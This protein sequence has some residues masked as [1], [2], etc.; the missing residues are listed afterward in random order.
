[1]TDILNLTGNDDRALE[2]GNK[3][4]S[5]YR[6]LLYTVLQ[7]PREKEQGGLVIA[8]SSSNPGEGVTYVS[9]ALVHELAKCGL[10]SVAGVNIS[11]LKKLHEPTVEAI[12]DSMSRMAAPAGG[13]GKANGKSKSL[14][15]TPTGGPWEARWQYRRDCINLLRAEFDYTIIDCPSLGESAELLGIAPFVDGIVLVV[16][17][18]RTLRDQPRQAEQQISAVGGTLLGYILNKRVYEAPRWLRPDA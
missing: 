8:M 15:F 12:R 17:A 6:T 9:R 4:S 14:T 13:D 1:M 10:T 7:K 5:I 18:N 3:R 2:I 11:F 16:E